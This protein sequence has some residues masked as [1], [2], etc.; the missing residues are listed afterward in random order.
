[1]VHIFCKGICNLIVF[2]SCAVASN[3]VS[4]CYRVDVSLL[5][6]RKWILKP[7][8]TL[9]NIEKKSS[10]MLFAIGNVF[11][12][13][14]TSRNIDNI[15]CPYLSMSESSSRLRYGGNLKDRHVHHYLNG[16]IEDSTLGSAIFVLGDSSSS[17]FYDYGL[18][19]EFSCF[20][21]DKKS[22]LRVENVTRPPNHRDRGGLQCADNKVNRIGSLMH[23]GV[24]PID[25]DYH[26]YIKHYSENGNKIVNSVKSIITAFNEFQNRSKDDENVLFVFQT[27]G[28]DLG[29]YKV[30]Y[31]QNLSFID[32]MQEFDRN[33]TSIVKT[34]QAKL[35]PKDTLILETNH[36]AVFQKQF[37]RKK[38]LG[39]RV[40][41]QVIAEFN[42]GIRVM[43]DIIWKLSGELKLPVFDAFTIY[44]EMTFNY[45]LQDDRSG[46]HQN[47]RASQL[48]AQKFRLQFLSKT[49]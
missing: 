23:F 43:N 41:E 34:L 12:S 40:S 21:S 19:Y 42:V 9:P 10:L 17:L 45:V 16:N 38:A 27:G 46:Y 8:V 28:W 13:T 48:L 37:A 44:N 29:R 18:S 15:K 26:Y 3:V 30:Q 31:M 47:T 6:K 25:N 7:N 39:F 14:E 24:N 36:L 35:R 1:M 11:F 20:W 32:W 4:K 2:I 33:Y 5:T 22:T 49:N